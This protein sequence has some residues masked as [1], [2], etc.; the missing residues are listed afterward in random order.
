MALFR[1]YE[2]KKYKYEGS[3][4]RKVEANKLAAKLRKRGKLVRIAKTGK[5]INTLYTLYSRLSG[6]W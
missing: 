1:I 6:N 4:R 2:G 3:E 5:G